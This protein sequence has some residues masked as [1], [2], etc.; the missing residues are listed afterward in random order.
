MGEIGSYYAQVGVRGVSTVQGAFG[1]VK[2]G[3]TGMA[4]AALAPINRLG[5]SLMRL[6]NPLTAVA[7]AAGGAFAAFKLAGLASDAEEIGGKFAVV[8]RNTS[9]QAR[10]TAEDL[11]RYMGAS[12]SEVTA[13]LAGLGD[14][15]K[16]LGFAED[17]ALQLSAT[18]TRL[19]ADL[20]SFNNISIDEALQ[21][22]QGTL[23]GSHENALKF[24]VVINENTLKAKMA[25]LGTDKLTGAAFEQAKVFARLRLLM[26][27][28]KDA[29]GD[30]GRTSDSY[31]NT[32]KRMRS[33]LKELGETL[34]SFLLPIFKGVGN[35]ISAVAE[36]ANQL[37]SGEMPELQSALTTVRDVL[38]GIA[39]AIRG[40]SFSGWSTQLSGAFKDAADIL[41]HAIDQCRIHRI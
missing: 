30:L 16:P 8:F 27:G 38:D 13:S 34:G 11:K 6:V 19:A 15:F 21:R 32:M 22:L 25:E 9:D 12:T 36:K 2:Q 24:G 7:S 1:K 5:S 28:T 39:A 4:S 17:E 33:T 35:I 23:I 40:S 20:A 10:R 41:I 18:M 29:Q 3:L 31:A 14:L 26:D 37:V